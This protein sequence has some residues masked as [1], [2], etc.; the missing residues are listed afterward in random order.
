MT[1]LPKILVV[2]DERFLRVSLTDYLEDCGF[3]VQAAASAEEGLEQ[4]ERD[5]A[6]LCIVDMRLPGMNGNEFILRAHA[7]DPRIRFIIFTGSVD[8]CLPETLR[9]LGLTLDNIL[10]KPLTDMAELLN[11]ITAILQHEPDFPTPPR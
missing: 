6:D 5:S 4:L 11:K 7:R 3:P 10:F 1:T 9:K 2:D 8:Y